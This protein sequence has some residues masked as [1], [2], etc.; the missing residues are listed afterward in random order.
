MGMISAMTDAPTSPAEVEKTR[1]EVA[2][3]ERTLRWSAFSCATGVVLVAIAFGL[4]IVDMGHGG[5]VSMLAAITLLLCFIA[6]FFGLA[7][8]F[9][10]AL[11]RET[12]GVRAAPEW[13]APCGIGGILA[14]FAVGLFGILT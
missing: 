1:A 6:V 4:S 14:A 13:A 11:A 12:P 10:M 7:G 5:D 8:L 3:A 9:G 2:K